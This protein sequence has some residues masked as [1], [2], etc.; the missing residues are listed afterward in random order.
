MKPYLIPEGLCVKPLINPTRSLT[1][2]RYIPKPTRAESDIPF[3]LLGCECIKCNQSRNSVW[4]P[5]VK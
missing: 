4:R 3:Y 5:Q 2:I 1:A